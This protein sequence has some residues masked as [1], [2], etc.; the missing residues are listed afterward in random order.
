MRLRT[1]GTV[2]IGAAAGYIGARS[3]MDR[4]SVSKQIPRPLRERLEN[5]GER[6]RQAREETLAVRAEME[7]VRY[8]AEE[9]LTAEYLKRAGRT[10][11]QTSSESSSTPRAE[12]L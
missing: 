10:T 6:L 9:E 7:Q 2:A 11:V 1:L 8:D 3:L 12:N 4:P 5:L